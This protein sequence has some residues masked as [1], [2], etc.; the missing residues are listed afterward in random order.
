MLVN[1][2]KLFLP[3]PEKGTIKKVLKF[4]KVDGE[5]ISVK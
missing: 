4:M 2:F 3:N 5:V 1:Y